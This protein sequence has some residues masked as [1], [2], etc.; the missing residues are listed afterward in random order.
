MWFLILNLY[1]YTSNEL[2]VSVRNVI[3]CGTDCIPWV[4]H[5]STTDRCLSWQDTL[6]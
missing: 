6:Q 3:Y 2:N 5:A 1:I 4:Q